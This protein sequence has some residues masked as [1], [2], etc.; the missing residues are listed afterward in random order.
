MCHYFCEF[1]EKQDKLRIEEVRSDE[2]YDKYHIKYNGNNSIA[3]VYDNDG[4]LSFFVNEVNGFYQRIDFY[5]NGNIAFIAKTDIPN[6]DIQGSMY[7]FFES[8]GDLSDSYHYHNGIRVGLS[9]SFHENSDFIKEVMHYDSLGKVYH[10]RTFDNK[11]K[12]ISEEGHE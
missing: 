6:G 4:N 10:R 9:K 8:N 5:D 7:Y 1:C 11:G 3:L 2:Q 12:L